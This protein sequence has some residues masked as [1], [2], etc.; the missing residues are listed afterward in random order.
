MSNIRILSQYVVDSYYSFLKRW[1]DNLFYAAQTLSRK[2]DSVTGWEDSAYAKVVETINQIFK[3]L[4]NIFDCVGS[5][6]CAL[7]TISG[8]ISNYT[9]YNRF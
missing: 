8:E 2:V 7:K 6:E 1:E 4:N 3:R 9:N 5:L